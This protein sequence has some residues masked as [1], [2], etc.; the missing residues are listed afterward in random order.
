MSDDAIRDDD[1]IRGKWPV[2]DVLL[3][4]D[5]APRDTA[6]QEKARRK[7]EYEALNRRLNTARI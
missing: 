7:A 3:R 5:T 1:A 2:L 6:D 4:P